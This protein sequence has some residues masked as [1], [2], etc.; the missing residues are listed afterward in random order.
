MDTAEPL[1]SVSCITYNHA[2]YIRQCLDG[3]VMQKTTFPFE[4]L[5]HDD[6]S[7]DGTAEIIKEY[8]KKY[9]HIIKPIYEEENQWKKGRR[10]TRVFNYPR[11]KGKYLALCEGDDYWTDPLKL[12]K[13][14]DFLEAHLDYGLV[15]TDVNFYFQVQGTL[16]SNYIAS[17]RINRSYGF[18]EHL[19][20]AGYIAPC[21]WLFRRE[22]MHSYV[23]KNYVDTTFPLAL[24]IWAKSMIKFMPDVTAVYRVLDESA[25]HSLSL[26]KMYHFSQGVFQIQKDYIEKYKNIVSD[27]KKIEIYL[28]SYS[29]MLTSAIVLNDEIMLTEVEL[30]IKKNLIFSSNYFKVFLLITMQRNYIMKTVLQLVL[31]RRIGLKV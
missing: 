9:P 11:A 25:S 6:A 18:I 15:Y 22:L 27:K 14:V 8:E 3:F 20:N 24:D 12:Q 10:G 4:V 21:T 13:Q 1:V 5:I 17:N 2:L 29:R 16:M 26:R 28:S 30:F 19:E 23:D 31:K 7:T